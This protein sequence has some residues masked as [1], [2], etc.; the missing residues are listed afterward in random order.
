M[1]YVCLAYKIVVRM[2][3]TSALQIKSMLSLNMEK[4]DIEKYE[5]MFS[6][7]MFYCG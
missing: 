2:E 3:T 4:K 7:N 1:C 5:K 6:G